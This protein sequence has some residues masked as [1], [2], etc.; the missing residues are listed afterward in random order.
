MNLD[1]L[2]ILRQIPNQ[3]YVDTGRQIEVLQVHHLYQY[4]RY[5][6]Q[7]LKVMTLGDARMVVPFVV[8]DT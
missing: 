4:K 2:P 7:V 3:C 5:R 8:I 1:S 6:G